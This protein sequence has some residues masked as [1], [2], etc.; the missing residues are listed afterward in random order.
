MERV[1]LFQYLYINY[2]SSNN[3][4]IKLIVTDNRDIIL[5]KAKGIF[6]IHAFFDKNTQ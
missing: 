1:E 4:I 2:K 5:F 3:A 6:S